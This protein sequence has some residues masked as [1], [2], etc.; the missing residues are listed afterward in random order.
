VR[1]AL[2]EL[3][4]DPAESVSEFVAEAELHPGESTGTP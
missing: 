1:A 3:V 4:D 2:Q